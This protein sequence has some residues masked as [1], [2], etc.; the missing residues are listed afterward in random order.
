[1]K[2]KSLLTSALAIVMVGA[3]S[4]PVSAQTVSGKSRGGEKKQESRGQSGRTHSERRNDSKSR[5]QQSRQRQEQSRRDQERKREDAR[6]ASEQSRRD[7]ESRARTQQVNRQREAEK[8]RKQADAKRRADEARRRSQQEAQR[9]SEES[10]RRAEEVRRRESQSRVG[11]I[12]QS[13]TQQNRQ[14]TLRVGRITQPDRR[15]SELR[16]REAANRLNAERARRDA[17]IRRREEAQRRSEQ[18]RRNRER[19]ADDDWLWDRDG[20]TIRLDRPATV[21][22]LTRPR[23]ESWRSG[24]LRVSNIVSQPRYDRVIFVDHSPRKP[25]SPPWW[26]NSRLNRS[27][28]V[29]VSDSGRYD[30]WDR[31][32]DDGYRDDCNIFVDNSRWD[33]EYGY[34]NSVWNSPTD[35]YL[36]Y[37]GYESWQDAYDRR[38]EKKNEWRSIAYVSGAVML[39]GLLK[40]DDTLTF[41]GGA[42]ALYSLTRYEADRKSQNDLKRQR[43]E[44]FTRGVY[45]RDGV[46]YNRRT[47]TK[48]G[49]K[50]YQF[51]RA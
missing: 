47:V 27:P 15:T 11:Q 46:R 35:P 48:D 18:E 26:S 37:N 13:R 45:Y 30:D 39:Y 44:Y 38:Q 16:A 3:F 7:A 43:A 23:Y 2:M 17:E 10:R 14:N 24:T 6:R 4:L 40:G 1:M 21:S 31:Y 36:A 50:Y 8:S 29:Y 9:R 49:Q 22:N 12:S 5:E 51:V 33:N 25:A 20:R 42:G 19:R 34:G 41:A 32:G 28:V